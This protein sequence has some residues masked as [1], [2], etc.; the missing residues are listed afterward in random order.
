MKDRTLQD[1]RTEEVRRH[2]PEI[3]KFIAEFVKREQQNQW[4][5]CA[6]MF[7]DPSDGDICINFTALRLGLLQGK[8]FECSEDIYIAGDIYV[9]DQWIGFINST[10][11][12]TGAWYTATI[13]LIPC[14][15]PSEMGIIRAEVRQ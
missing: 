10:D 1:I 5:K 9:G 15:K 6:E 2:F 8:A 11:A 3:D 14:A 12:P 4:I 7:Y 13:L